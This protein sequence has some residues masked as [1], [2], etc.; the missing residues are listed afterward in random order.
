MPQT[1][2]EIRTL[3]YSV[4]TWIWDGGGPLDHSIEAQA[5]RGRK[6]GRVR[7]GEVAGQTVHR[8]EKRI[9]D[10]EIVQAVLE[11]RIGEVRGPPVRAPE[12][13]GFVYRKARNARSRGRSRRT[14]V[15]VETLGCRRRIP[16][17]VVQEKSAMTSHHAELIKALREA[18]VLLRGYA[19]ADYDSWT[20][21]D[22]EFDDDDH[23]N[24]DAAAW[25]DID[26]LRKVLVAHGGEAEEFGRSL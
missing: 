23:A 16:G 26:R 22:G 18:I 12:I 1:E 9:E 19:Q 5:R 14:V 15:G 6:S 10:M 2:A 7:R 8:P 21:A 4:A 25:G 17:H 20:N 13:D 24:E 11:A 3:A